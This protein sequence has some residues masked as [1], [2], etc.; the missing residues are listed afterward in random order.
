VLAERIQRLR[1]VIDQA[2]EI[3]GGAIHAQ[4]GIDRVE[5]AYRILRT[6]ALALI[7]EM[8]DRLAE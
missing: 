5:S 8:E 2:S 7:D 6:E 3:H 4:R 1:E